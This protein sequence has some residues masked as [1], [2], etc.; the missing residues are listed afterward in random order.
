M[1]AGSDKGKPRGPEMEILL[2]VRPK[3]VSG[4]LGPGGAELER[5]G[6]RAGE[7]ADSVAKIA[8]EFRSRLEKTLRADDGD[9][10]HTDS[11]ELGF[12]IAVQAQAGVVIA[13]AVTGATF[14]AKLTLKAPAAER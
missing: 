10:W 9:G 11:V 12:E 5:F 4:D 8:E 3:S 2:E 7:I 13:R 1:A 14:S 6:R